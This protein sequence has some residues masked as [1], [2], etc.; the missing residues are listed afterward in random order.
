MLF[1]IT[2]RPLNQ[3][4]GETLFRF[5]TGLS[6]ESLAKF[7]P[8]AVFPAALE[9]IC[10]EDAENRFL[11]VDENGN[12]VGYLFFTRQNAVTC[13]MKLAV[14]DAYA[15]RGLGKQMVGQAQKIARERD[16]QLLLAEIY[17][18]DLAAS[19]LLQHNGFVQQGRG[20]N[21]GLYYLC[22]LCAEKSAETRLLP[23]CETALTA[24]DGTPYRI[25]SLRETDGEGLYR[26]FR[27][28]SPRGAALYTP[29]PTDR[30]YLEKL[31]R[32]CR[33][34]ENFDRFLAVFDRD[35][36]EAVG[37]YVFLSSLQ[38]TLPSM[39]IGAADWTTGKGVGR[40]MLTFIQKRAHYDYGRAVMRLITHPS[41]FT[42]Q[43]LYKL[44][45]FEQVG[46]A[47]NGELAMIC[48]LNAQKL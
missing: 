33:K 11:A 25:R 34:T 8:H 32:E 28:M 45:G 13:W 18:T 21:G 40:Q 3:T 38:T 47:G 35:G 9:K 26:F 17:G 16:W 4:D 5:F 44:N 41:N 39:G 46:F 14:L 24:S 6:G 42:A 29:H 36:Q 2:L 7:A 19:R 43:K 27:E 48:D 37:G 1:G 20:M 31:C 10:R 30:E 12:A 23:P 22:D 15:G